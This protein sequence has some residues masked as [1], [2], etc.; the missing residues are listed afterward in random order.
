MC[1]SVSQPSV[2]SAPDPFFHK[3]CLIAVPDGLFSKT[4]EGD[5]WRDGRFNFQA[6]NP[7]YH[8]GIFC[9]GNRQRS[10][11][12]VF[13]LERFVLLFDCYDAGH[14]KKRSSFAARACDSKRLIRLQCDLATAAVTLGTKSRGRD[15]FV[16]H[17]FDSP[18]TA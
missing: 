9:L 12:A 4:A 5:C 15:V 18:R 3:R 13:R 6:L 2:Y 8:L 14:G 11:P 17:S 16:R 7:L 10:T 1:W